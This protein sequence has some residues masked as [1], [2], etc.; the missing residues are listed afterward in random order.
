MWQKLHE[1][2]AAF[3]PDE[4]VLTGLIRTETNDEASPPICRQQAW[5]STVW[6]TQRSFRRCFTFDQGILTSAFPLHDASRGVTTTRCHCWC[7]QCGYEVE[8][9]GNYSIISSWFDTAAWPLDEGRIFYPLTVEQGKH[10]TLQRGW[11]CIHTNRFEGSAWVHSAESCC[12][13]D[14][15]AVSLSLR[16][17]LKCRVQHILRPPR[18]LFA[19]SLLKSR[20]RTCQIGFIIS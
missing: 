13:R 6:F 1:W 17:F 18:A 4:S 9:A 19:E 7:L 16:N 2:T 10:Y 20:L 12:F 5:Q 3:L 15:K 11:G 14:W 8:V